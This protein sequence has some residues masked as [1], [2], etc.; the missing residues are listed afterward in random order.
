[1]EL[2][3]NSIEKNGNYIFDAGNLEVCAMELSDKIN[4]PITDCSTM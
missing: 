3:D 1:M 2:K 4:K